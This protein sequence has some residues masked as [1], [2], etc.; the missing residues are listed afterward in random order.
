MSISVEKLKNE[1]GSLEEVQDETILE[2]VNC[3]N[4]LLNQ[5]E[6]TWES[7]TTACKALA[8]A[9]RTASLRTP[10]GEA[11]IIESLSNLLKSA[12]GNQPEFQIQA[13]RVLGNLCFDHEAN[14]K[15]VKAAGIVSLVASYLNSQRPDLIRTICG[16]YLNSSMDYASIQNEIAECGAAKSLVDLIQ[17][18]KEDDGSITM[19][20]KIIDNLVAEENARK[21]I[22]TPLTVKTYIIMIEHLYKSEDYIDDL[23][24]LEN[25][26]DTL[27]QLIMDDDNLQN[28][29]INLNSLD[30]LLDLLENSEIE[31]EDKQDKEKLEEIRK[32]INKI[33]VYATSTDSKMQELYNNQHVLSRFLS[34]A[35]SKSEVAHQCAVYALGNL[36][37][38]DQNCTELVEKYNLS[39]TLLDLYQNTENAT[40]QY[41]ISGCLKHLCLPMHNK[42][43]IGT[44]GCIRIL[45]PT[46]EESKD[47]LKRN[48]FLTIGIIKLLCTG[49]YENCKRVIQ[50]NNTLSLV[51]SFIRRVDDVA[52]KSEATRILTNL[53]KIV[54]VQA[55]NT[56][57]KS[58]VIE[59]HIIEPIIELIQT[60]TFPILK[61][62]GI[63]ALTLIF[64]DVDSKFG[65]DKALP[66]VIAEPLT[67]AIVESDE[68]PSQEVPEKRSFLQ[69]LIDD[70]CLQRNELPV[71]IKCN[72]CVLLVKI[73]E[74]AKSGK[75]H[76]A[77]ANVFIYL[78]FIVQSQ[79]D[80]VTTIKSSSLNQLKQIQSGTELDR[81]VHALT[82]A[83]EK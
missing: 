56:E 49:N 79:E 44:E 37:R 53:I 58:K 54:W 73:V 10:L 83:L 11:G 72:A 14:R 47:M 21:I 39:K 61:N 15:H 35:T 40:F 67:D 36:A 32:T 70:I 74:A 63:M 64:S 50:E 55:D 4:N 1:L 41:A 24:N 46:L 17:P 60:S 26:T 69:V 59:A 3:L 28:E 12:S 76:K 30:M 80:I 68:N 13:L 42:S 5:Q 51:T 29:I 65:W 62:D 8:D 34:M 45:S 78:G 18:D 25:L 9:L 66:L 77:M 19:A 31:L 22:A 75:P 52:A 81:Y 2:P 82:K 27:L 20:L 57:L 16:F 33:V 38:S 6:K 23:D 7:G 48:Q 43:I 71:Q